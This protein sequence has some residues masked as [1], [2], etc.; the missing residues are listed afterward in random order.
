[1][2]TLVININFYVRMYSVLQI[3]YLFVLW[4]NLKM[5]PVTLDNYMVNLYIANLKL[6]GFELL[7]LILVSFLTVSIKCWQNRSEP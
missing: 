3:I 6:R 1:M 4:D 2:Y 5:F 7:S